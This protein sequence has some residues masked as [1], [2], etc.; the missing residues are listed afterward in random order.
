MV[1]ARLWQYTW[2]LQLFNLRYG[3]GCSGP[4]LHRQLPAVHA[5]SMTVFAVT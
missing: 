5:L 4:A 3:L 1:T 2:F